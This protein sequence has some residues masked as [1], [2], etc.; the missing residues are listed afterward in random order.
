MKSDENVSGQW[1]ETVSGIKIEFLNPRP[2]QIKITDIAHALSNNCRFT[3]QCRKF[4]SV[5]EHS[6]HVARMLEGTPLEVQLA[7]L[8]HDASEA[9]LAD[10]ATPVKRELPEYKVIEDNLMVAIAKKYNFEWP[11]HPAVK[12]ADLMALSNE[13]HHLLPSRGNEWDTWRQ[14]KRPPII[15]SYRPIGM[16][17]DTARQVFLDRFYELSIAIR[18]KNNNYELSRIDGSPAWDR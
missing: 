5:A 2:E 7:G 16:V 9:Y 6:W 1:I 15:D 4:Y 11:M 14:V 3:G 8:L 17:P 10:I 13:A 12:Y 18:E